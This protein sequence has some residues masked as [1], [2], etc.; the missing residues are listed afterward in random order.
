MFKGQKFN[1]SPVTVIVKGVSIVT[2][3]NT[4]HPFWRKNLASAVIREVG[5]GVPF[6]ITEGKVA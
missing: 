2:Y 3:A 6:K 4:R 1:G 5:V